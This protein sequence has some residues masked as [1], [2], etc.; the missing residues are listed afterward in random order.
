MQKIQLILKNKLRSRDL[1]PK[2]S[3]DL[4]LKRSRDLK[5]KRSR[6]LKL[7]RSKDLKPKRSRDLKPKRSRDLKL[8][9]SR[10]LKPKR[11]RDLKPKRSK[12]LKPKRSRD[13]KP[14]RN[15]DLKLKRSKDLKPKRSKDLKPKRSRDLK[16]KRSKDLKL[17]RN[18]DLKPKRSRDLKLKRS[19]DLKLKRNKDLKP[20][21]SKDLKPKRSRLEAEEKQRL[22]AEEKQRLEAEEKQRLEAEEKQRLEAEEKQRLEAEEKQRLEA[23]E[24]QRL[25]AEEKQRLEAEEKQRLEAEEKQRLEAEE[26]QRLEAEEKQLRADEEEKQQIKIKLLEQQMAFED[27]DEDPPGI[28]SDQSGLHLS[29]LNNTA[30]AEQPKATDGVRNPIVVKYLINMESFPAKTPEKALAAIQ[31]QLADKGT[32][33]LSGS[34]IIVTTDDIEAESVLK[35]LGKIK[36]KE[37][38]LEVFITKVEECVSKTVPSITVKPIKEAKSP[39]A[40]SIPVKQAETKVSTAKDTH[41]QLQID[42]SKFPSK[43]GA[44]VVKLLKDMLNE[45]ESAEVTEDFNVIV[46]VNPENVE[47]VS[48][49][50]GKMKI[51]DQK[52]EVSVLESQNQKSQSVAQKAAEEAERQR[53]IEED[54]KTEKQRQLTK[55][56]TSK[57]VVKYNINMSTFSESAPAKVIDAIKTS[58]ADKATAEL[59]GSNIIVTTNE[60]DSESVLKKLGKI[61][62]KDQRLEEFITVLNEEKPADKVQLFVDLSKFPNKTAAKVVKTLKDALKEDERAEITQESNIIVFVNA[63]NVEAVTKFICKLKIEGTKLEVSVFDRQHP[64]KKEDPIIGSDQSGLHLSNLNNTAKAEQPK[65]TDGVRNPIVVKYLINM[66]SFPAKT[67]EKALAAI[68]TQLADKGTAELSGSSIIVTTDDIEAE[69]VLKKLGKIKIK[70]QKLEV[71][72]TKVEEC[73][74]KTV[75]SITVKPIKEAKSP[76]AQSIPV[77]QAE[78]KVSTA[79]DTHVQLQIDLSKFPSK[80][81]AKVVKLLKDML[82]ENESAEVTEDFNVIVTVNPENVEPVSKK[83][84]KMKIEDQKLEVSVLESQNQKSQSVAQKAAEE[85]ERQRQIEEDR[86]TE[87]QRQLTKEIT[88]KVVVKYNINMSTFSESAPAKVIDAIKTSLADKATAELSGSNII[89]TTNESDS[90]SV[91]K[92]LGKIKIKDQRL[93]EFITV[94]NEE[95]PADKVQLFVDLSKFPN[96]TAAKVVKTLKDALKEDERAE[97]TQES[98]IIVFVNPEN[99]EAVT[100]FIC[101]LKIDGTKLEV[102]VLTK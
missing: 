60:S 66:E 88:S 1:K 65:A 93:E 6:D 97:I 73:V 41:V 90:E 53:Q 89:V 59:S 61:K 37:Q 9:R 72:I 99:V 39:E 8:K 30:K 101:K 36:I 86:K 87:K 51:E 83:I 35:K 92:K 91:L 20:K 102:S 43:T 38:K 81:G 78:T 68:Q 23:E 2:R 22:E 24:K 74:S 95:K 84:G 79:K 15:K 55:E 11:S 18:K 62:I 67:P 48:K 82:N 85:A 71:F 46:T 52:L 42:L 40:Q 21:R 4:K 14:K 19:R 25:E 12:D 7:K 75:P 94:L 16:P 31:T 28:N 96:K 70:E 10:D 29:N 17:K 5:P 44:K 63:E 58:L 3:R 50:I 33:E 27:L 57:V 54:R 64:H 49:K 69:S 47:P 100:K 77:K 34:S 76:E 32:A 80:T 56:I 26:K 13:L 98:N 45:N